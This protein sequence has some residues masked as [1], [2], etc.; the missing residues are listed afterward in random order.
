MLR[1]TRLGPAAGATALLAAG[2]AAWAG[3]TPSTWVYETVP[4]LGRGALVTYLTAI[5]LACLVS[6]PRLECLEVTASRRLWPLRVRLVFAALAGTAVVCAAVCGVVGS[7]WHLYPLML[8]GTLLAC[9]TFTA[10]TVL[11]AHLVALPGLAYT[12]ACCFTSAGQAEW[13]LLMTT[14]GNTRTAF[15]L[16]LGLAGTAIFCVVG[17]RPHPPTEDW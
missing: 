6:L 8:G 10:S 9:A 1:V 11:P 12:L 15:T 16:G 14:P 5:L 4:S 17:A 13:D 7:A 2:G 3:T